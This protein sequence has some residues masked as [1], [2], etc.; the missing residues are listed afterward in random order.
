MSAARSYIPPIEIGEVMRALAGGRMIASCHRG[1]APGDWVH[2]PF[3]VQ[4]HAVSDGQNAYKIEVTG[5]LTPAAYLGMLGLTGLTAY[6]GPLDVGRLSQ[7]ETVLVSGAAGAVRT[8]V[9]QIAKIKSAT[10]VRIADGPEAVTPDTACGARDGPISS[11]K[12]RRLGAGGR[13]PPWP[14][15]GLEPRRSYLHTR[16]PHCDRD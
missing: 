5:R 6:F 11:T 16:R 14:E 12:R 3:G 13:F 10:E 2:G 8:A 9:D 7:G 4:E 15:P 1:F